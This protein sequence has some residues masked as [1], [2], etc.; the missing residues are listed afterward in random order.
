MKALCSVNSGYLAISK[1]LAGYHTCIIIQS[2]RII[3]V[4]SRGITI[5]NGCTCSILYAYSTDSHIVHYLVNGVQSVVDLPAAS[6][7]LVGSAVCQ[8]WI[9]RLQAVCTVCGS[10][11]VDV[12]SGAG[13]V[14]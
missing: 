1:S 4:T 5:Y 9:R 7:P 8:A 6:C 2:A 11:V 3:I 14:L 10:G 13:G 12:C